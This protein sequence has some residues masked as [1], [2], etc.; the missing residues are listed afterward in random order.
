M[1]HIITSL[2]FAA[3]MLPAPALA[4]KS[5]VP[6]EPFYPWKAENFAIEAPIGDRQGNAERGKQLVM[7]RKKGNC[8]ACHMLPIEDAEFPGQ[9]GPPLVA[10]GA[11][12][13][14]AQIRLRVANEQLINPATIMPPYYID[15]NELNNV[16]KKFKGKTILSAQEVE[17]VVVYL[18][19]LK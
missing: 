16:K 4:E 8:I 10:I 9:L 11:R 6:D 14:P 13:S 3:L 1:K 17:D 5:K 7:D 19:S 2:I 18:S 12:Y 15:P